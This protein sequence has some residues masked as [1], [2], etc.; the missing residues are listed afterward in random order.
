MAARPPHPL[1]VGIVLFD[2]VEELDFVGPMEV[3]GVAARLVP[4]S[5]TC[6][7]R[8]LGDVHEIRARY[9][10]RVRVDQALLPTDVFDILLVPGGPG[11]Q[12]ASKDG[13]LRQAI[14]AHHARGALL[15]SVC[16]GALVLAEAGVLN[17]RAATT[18]WAALDELRRYPRIAVR[19]GVRFVDEGTIVTSAGISAG[20]D[21]ALH[22]VA[23]IVGMET[24]L[25]VAHRMEYAWRDAPAP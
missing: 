19:D 10:L 2:E 17:D 6:S 24:A 1:H 4:G 20:I 15:A 23:R 22:L 9:G 16:T 11:R 14:L 21:M 12:P 8:G 25:A 13:R 7:L 18:H 3:F 5:M